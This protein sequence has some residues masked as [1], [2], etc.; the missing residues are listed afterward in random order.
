MSE[1]PVITGTSLILFPVPAVMMLPWD[2]P[3]WPPLVQAQGVV[4]TGSLVLWMTISG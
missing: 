2:S 3:G 4:G 1:S